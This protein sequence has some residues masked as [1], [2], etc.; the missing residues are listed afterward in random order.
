MVPGG[1]FFFISFQE[2][3]NN[4]NYYNKNF[5]IDGDKKVKNIGTIKTGFQT[6]KI[7]PKWTLLLRCFTKQ[8]VRVIHNLKS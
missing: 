7:E 1:C 6:S 8:T 3:W 2:I 4:L 5:E